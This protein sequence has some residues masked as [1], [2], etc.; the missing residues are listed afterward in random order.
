MKI[1]KWL[2]WVAIVLLLLASFLGL[3]GC[4]K[5]YAFNSIDVTGADWG[6]NLALPD[7]NGNI[8]RSK[9]FKGKV[10]AVFFGFLS[11]PDACPNNLSQMAR[12]KKMLGENSNEFQVFFVSIDPERDTPEN[13]K[14]FLLSFDKEFRGLIATS[15]LLDELKKEF[16]LVVQ[17]IPV[18][19]SQIKKSQFYLIDHTTHTYIFDKDGTLRLISPE[20]ITFTKLLA[21]IKYLINK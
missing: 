3:F 21:D 1:V 17:K 18:D 9:D 10:T 11:C 4:E 8:V 19:N 15:D 14:N 16:K 5:Q 20:S 13:L 2:A 7:L 12:L 6:K